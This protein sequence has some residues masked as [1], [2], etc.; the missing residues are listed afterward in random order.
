M[1]VC[2]ENLKHVCISI[3]L[4]LS[5]LQAQSVRLLSIVLTMTDES[6]SSKVRYIYE[7]VPNEESNGM[8]GSKK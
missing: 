8:Y 7:L 6:D 5:I 1:S 4:R 3:S 2:A